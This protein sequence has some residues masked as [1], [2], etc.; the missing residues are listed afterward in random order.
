MATTAEARIAD[1]ELRRLKWRSRR[2]L[3][4]CDLLVTRFFE[5]HAQAG[6]TKMQAEGLRILIDLYY[7]VLLDLL[8]RRCEPEGEIDR[9]D[10]HHVLA[11]MR[12]PAFGA[13]LGDET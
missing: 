3:L 2:G 6:L 8:L 4:E 1:E 10:V 5:L 9:E 13:S 11:Q 12:G 7:P